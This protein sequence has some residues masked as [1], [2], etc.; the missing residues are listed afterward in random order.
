MRS[1]A[2]VHHVLLQCLIVMATPTLQAAMSDLPE[3]LQDILKSY[4]TQ[5]QKVLKETKEKNPES[6]YVDYRDA[7]LED[8]HLIFLTCMLKSMGINVDISRKD[9]EL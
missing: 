7:V 3:L 2:S 6:K 8:K 4:N 1:V 5:V 9:H